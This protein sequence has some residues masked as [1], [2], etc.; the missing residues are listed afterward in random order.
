[1]T[2]PGRRDRLSQGSPAW[3]RGDHRARAPRRLSRGSPAWERGDHRRRAPRSFVARF[4]PQGPGDGRGTLLRDR[5]REVRRRGRGNGRW[6]NPCARQRPAWTRF[7]ASG[8]CPSRSPVRK[9]VAPPCSSGQAPP[10]PCVQRRAKRV[11]CNASLGRSCSGGVLGARPAIDERR[12]W[13]RRVVA[14]KGETPFVMAVGA[15]PPRTNRSRRVRAWNRGDDA[16]RAAGP[17]PSR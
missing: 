5:S 6:S 1:M 3:E 17:E 4:L 12:L 9:S 10:N 13:M 8:A 16:G 7:E 2:E 11:R 14:R 15:N